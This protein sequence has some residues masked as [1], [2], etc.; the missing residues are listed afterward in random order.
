[1]SDS[2]TLRSASQAARLIVL[3]FERAFSCGAELSLLRAQL[4]RQHLLASAAPEPLD[5]NS[6]AKSRQVNRPVAILTRGVQRLRRIGSHRKCA[7]VTRWEWMT[8]SNQVERE[9]TDSSW[10][11]GPIKRVFAGVSSHSRTG[12]GQVRWTWSR[13]VC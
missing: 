10:M 8:K 3:M 13:Y 9:A 12:S 1:Q 7:G 6:R 4:A 2:P 5:K 11:P